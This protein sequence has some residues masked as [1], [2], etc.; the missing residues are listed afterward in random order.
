MYI[1]KLTTKVARHPLAELK[2]TMSK[3]LSHFCILHNIPKQLDEYN[4]SLADLCA[5]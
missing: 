5:P 2:K 4:Q 3:P 1:S